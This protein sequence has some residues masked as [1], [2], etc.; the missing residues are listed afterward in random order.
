MND[1]PQAPPTPGVMPH[2]VCRDAAA[3]IDF[4]K[5]AFGAEE[6][7]RL[8]TKDGK[9]MHAAVMINGGMV[10]LVDEMPGMAMASPQ[11]LG[12]S[13]VTL[14]MNVPDATGAIARA[15]G[16]G[17]TVIMEAQPMFWGDL[18]GMVADPFG[19][20]WSLATPLG[21][22]KSAAELRDAMKAMGQ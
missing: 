12:D 10:M 4:Y 17:A 1:T 19:H 21:P 14:H 2:L 13:P 18:Y 5:A 11:T 15:A 7:M 3:A 16:A 9:L 20:V 22:P 8:P 6:V